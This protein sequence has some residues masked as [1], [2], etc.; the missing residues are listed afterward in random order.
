MNLSAPARDR[1]L[2]SLTISA[3]PSGRTIGG[4]IWRIQ[5]GSAEV[6][7]AMDAN[8]RKEILLDGVNMDSLPTG[9]SVMIVNSPYTGT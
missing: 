2:H 5:C 9:P 8:L 6:L 7:Y 4:A 1:K 3:I